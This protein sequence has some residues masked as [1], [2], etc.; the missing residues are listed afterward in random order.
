VVVEVVVFIIQELQAQ[1]VQV[2]VELQVLAVV[3]LMMVTQEHQIQVA[4][5]VELLVGMHQQEQAV[6]EVQA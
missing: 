5:V 6:M 1:V 3:V 4:E 2:V